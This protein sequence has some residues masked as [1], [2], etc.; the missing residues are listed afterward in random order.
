MEPEKTVTMGSP[1]IGIR[2][3]RLE[4]GIHGFFHKKGKS[5]IYG[6]DSLGTHQGSCT[7]L[8]WVKLSNSRGAA[9]LAL[10]S[11]ASLALSFRAQRLRAPLGLHGQLQRNGY[12]LMRCV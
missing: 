10:C 4:H 6:E 9:Y 3:G 11:A 2:H 1:R 12:T 7:W 8:F 5:P